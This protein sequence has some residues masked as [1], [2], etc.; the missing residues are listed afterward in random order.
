MKCRSNLCSRGS[1]IKIDRC[2]RSDQRQHFFFDSGRVR[3]RK[4]KSVCL[5]RRGRSI[6]FD[7][8]GS[9]NPDQV[10]ST[11]TKDG[12]FELSPPGNDAK[13]ASQH[14][15]PREDEKVYMTSCKLSRESQTDKWIVY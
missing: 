12:P 1:G 7:S 14:H 9:S 11:L 2:D 10:W 3:S 8:C 15:H 6:R 5:T 4:N 13:C